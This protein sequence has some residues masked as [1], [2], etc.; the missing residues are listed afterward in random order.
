MVA[1]LDIAMMTTLS[2]TFAG[3][4][5]PNVKDQQAITVNMKCFLIL[6]SLLI[7]VK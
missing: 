3:N 1:T 6:L 2:L 4:V 7:K 5:I